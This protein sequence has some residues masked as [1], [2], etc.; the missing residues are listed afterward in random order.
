MMAVKG[1]P[2]SISQK[3]Q[4]RL[5]G[6]TAD[7]QQGIQRVTQA[8]GQAAVAKKDKWL[9]NVQAS[10]EKWARNTGRVSLSDWQNA[11]INVGVPR[12]AQGAQ[13]KQG[14]VTS[15]MQD[16]IPHL[17]RG[18]AAVNNMPDNTFEARIQRAVA[19]MRHNATF[20]R[21]S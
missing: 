12:I 3:W 2:E 15:F 7:I 13:A 20:K 16:F 6:A 21:T 11:A 10:Q 14:K 9:N 19:M 1:T 18:Q 17:E 8:P 5:S 4:T